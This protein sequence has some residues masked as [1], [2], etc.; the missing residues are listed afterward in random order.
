MERVTNFVR[1]PGTITRTGRTG[2][3][4]DATGLT[5]GPSGPPRTRTHA[6]PHAEPS[7]SP[8]CADCT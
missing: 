6:D 2:Y 8:H 4:R 1:Y 7:L 3:V 5:L